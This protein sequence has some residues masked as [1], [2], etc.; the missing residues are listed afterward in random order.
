MRAVL[1]AKI[2]AEINAEEAKKKEARKEEEEGQKA[3]KKS[4]KDAEK[5]APSSGKK[6]E[7]GAARGGDD[8]E[9]LL[10]RELEL[11]EYKERKK[12]QK[13]ERLWAMQR[14]NNQEGVGNVFKDKAKKVKATTSTQDPS[15]PGLP[16]SLEQVDLDK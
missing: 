12:I 11:E 2:Q 7:T 8:L 4:S 1:E 10:D 15:A 5:S 16:P 14:R 9:D 13:L 6:E 3:V